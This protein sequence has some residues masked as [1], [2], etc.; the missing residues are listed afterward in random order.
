MAAFKYLGMILANKNY[1][2]EEIKDSIQGMPATIGSRVFCFPV[3][4]L[5]T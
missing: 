5:K 4:C 2:N 1:F 3:W